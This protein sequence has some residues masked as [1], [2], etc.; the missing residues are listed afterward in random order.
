MDESGGIGAAAAAEVAAE[1]E[2]APAAAMEAAT[3]AEVREN[4]GVSWVAGTTAATAPPD[5]AGTTAAST[6]RSPPAPA[7]Q[8]RLM[9]VSCEQRDAPHAPPLTHSSVLQWVSSRGS[10]LLDREDLKRFEL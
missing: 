4:A 8:P 2:A 7:P 3:G 9:A 10:P 6:A 5:D 1:A